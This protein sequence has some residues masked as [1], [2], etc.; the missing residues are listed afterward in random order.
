M[1]AVPTVVFVLTAMVAIGVQSLPKAARDSGSNVCLTEACIEAAA[2]LFKTMNRSADPCDDFN[3]FACG[4]FIKE[5]VIPEDKSSYSTFTPTS[6]AVAERGRTILEEGP[7]DAD[8]PVFKKAKEHYKAC[9]DKPKLEEL[10]VEPAK[11]KLRELGGWPVLEGDN[12]TGADTFQWYNRIYDMNRLGFGKNYLFSLD[13]GTDDKNSSWRAIFLD[14][15]SLGMSREYLVKGFN[16]SDVQHYFTYMKE[17]AVLLGADPETAATELEETLLFELELAQVTAPREERRNHSLLYNPVVLGQYESLPGHPP[18]WTDYVDKILLDTHVGPDERIIVNDPNY[19]KN[20]S[21]IL[22]N[23]KPRVIANFLGWHA[24]QSL[25]SYLNQAARDI[26]QRFSKAL[27]GVDTPPPR[28][29]TCVEVVGFDTFSDAS[30]RIPAA[31][32]YVQRYFSAEAK[33][34]M[35]DMIKYIQQAFLQILDDLTWMDPKTKEKAKHKMLQMHQFIAYPDE[36]LD[37]D[38]VEKHHEGIEIKADDYLGNALRLTQWDKQFKFGRLREKVDKTSW[39]E[40]SLVA[41]VNAFYSSSENSIQFPAGI[42]QGAF[43][44]HLVPKYLNFGAIGGVIGHEITH[45]FDD[46]GRQFDVEGNLQDWWEEETKTQFVEKAKCIIDQYSGYKSV[47]VNMSLNG[48]TTQGEN[49]ADN[50]GI[51]EAYDGYER[52][53]KDHQEEDLLPGLNFTSQQLFWISWGQVWCSKYRDP[54]LRNQIQTGAHS[55]GEFRINGPM[56]N[57]PQFA[58]AFDCPVG[59]RMN[60][61]QR[62]SVW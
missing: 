7:T 33:E 53:V 56:S 1:M 4:K 9:M 20:V 6:E 14:Q 59:S 50:G 42:L 32:L 22:A 28:W 25:M 48:I 29:K 41:M 52:W 13:V 23:T 8:W 43:F 10:G 31:S 2:R 18:S 35:I 46:Q 38:I 60:P 44:N 16:D 62:C 61:S 26:R 5:S 49:I 24:A 12:W 21:R 11:A 57:S 55:P 39:L 30:F 36:I 54:A 37:R 34:A 3:E 58:K 45:G 17:T 15:P 51:K 47:Q 40:H 27:T 19:V